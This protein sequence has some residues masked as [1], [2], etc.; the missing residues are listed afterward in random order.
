MPHFVIQF[1]ELGAA[2][3]RLTV[4]RAA[5]HVLPPC[6]P[7]RPTYCRLSTLTLFVC[8]WWWWWWWCLCACACVSVCVCVCL[9][10]SLSLYVCVC[11][12]MR[13]SVCVSLCRCAS[14]SL[15]HSLSLSLSLILTHSHSLSL[16]LSL[17]MYVCVGRR[18][19]WRPSTGQGGEPGRA[20]WRLALLGNGSLSVWVC[21][22]PAVV[23]R[24]RDTLVRL[25]LAVS[26]GLDVARPHDT[27]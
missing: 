19:P 6:R 13:V 20:C 8:V 25:L 16:S 23:A 12:C 1:G 11:V 24:T 7:G 2:C 5:K 26:R 21:H 22:L 4:L 10:L 18:Y 3:R 17:A 27:R 14:L 9:S 15:T